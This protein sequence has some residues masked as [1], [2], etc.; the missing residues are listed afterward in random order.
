MDVLKGITQFNIDRNLKEF[1][2]Y[3]EY[4]M[5][6]SETTEFLD[7]TILGDE[8]EQVDA[9]ADTI[10]F[11]VGTL[12]KMGYCPEEV[13]KETLKEINSRQ[14]ELNLSTGKWEKNRLQDQST[15]YRANYSSCLVKQHNKNI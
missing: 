9:M 1:H 12:H 3:K 4:K 8:H 7:A 15:L 10:V 14:G 11:A 13:L 6:L 2:P 5:V